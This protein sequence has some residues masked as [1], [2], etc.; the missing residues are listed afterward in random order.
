MGV[1]RNVGGVGYDGMAIDKSVTGYDCVTGHY[2]L[3]GNPRI[4]VVGKI[5]FTLNVS[6]KVTS[7]DVAEAA[8]RSN[9]VECA[10][11]FKSIFL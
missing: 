9:P 2:R 4:P 10:A 5:P 11:K 8:Q 3:I 1:A 6:T 7:L